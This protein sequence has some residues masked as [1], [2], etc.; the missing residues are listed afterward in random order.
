MTL[1]SY[2]DIPIPDDF[3]LD[4]EALLKLKLLWLERRHDLADEAYETDIDAGF[5]IFQPHPDQE[6]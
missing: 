1:P 3:E 5:V 2:D 6:D 4:P